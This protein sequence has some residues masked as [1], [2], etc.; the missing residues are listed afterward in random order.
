MPKIDIINIIYFEWFFF[1]FI[2]FSFILCEQS[3]FALSADYL[4]ATWTEIIQTKPF[5]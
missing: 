4:I 1:F 5:E 2:R 3:I